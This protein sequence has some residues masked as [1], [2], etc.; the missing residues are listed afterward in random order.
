[1]DFGGGGVNKIL[2]FYIISIRF[3]FKK[4]IFVLY[5]YKKI[6][7]EVFVEIGIIFIM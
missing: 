7:K 2:I 4:Y 6:F 5:I 3:F 1:M